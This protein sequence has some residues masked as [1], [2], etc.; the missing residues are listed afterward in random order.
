M[1]L[2][3]VLDNQLKEDSFSKSIYEPIKSNVKNRVDK[4]MN[5]DKAFAEVA[6]MY[7]DKAGSDYSRVNSLLK[8]FKPKIK[9]ELD[10]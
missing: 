6:L 2:K 1:N 4:G 9:K 3:S 10:L 5:F 7:L 8:E